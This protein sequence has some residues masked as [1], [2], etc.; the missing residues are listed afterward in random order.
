[1]PEVTLEES[2]VLRNVDND[3]VSLEKLIELTGFD[4]GK[5]SSICMTLRLK[6]RLRYLPGNR[7]C[8]PRMV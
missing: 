5:I 3:G 2:M 7:V 6:G 1:M 8:L 4:V